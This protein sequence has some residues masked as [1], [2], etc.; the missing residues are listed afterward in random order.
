MSFSSA[1]SLTQT[2]MPLVSKGL[3]IAF[4]LIRLIT[5]SRVT[6]SRRCSDASR[7]LST[8]S[9]GQG[10]SGLDFDTNDHLYMVGHLVGHVLHAPT[11]SC[12]PLLSSRGCSST[13][14]SSILLCC[15]CCCSISPNRIVEVCCFCLDHNSKDSK[16]EKTLHC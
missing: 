4:R 8:R 6:G 9:N 10:V 12:C 7:L 15:F 5:S 13:Y 16:L 14:C 2:P 1:M 3:G 11:L